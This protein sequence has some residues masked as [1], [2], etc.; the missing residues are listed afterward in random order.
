MVDSA[1][2]QLLTFGAIV[3]LVCGF[4]SSGGWFGKVPD[5]LLHRVSIGRWDGAMNGANRWRRTLQTLTNS[6]S[7]ADWEVMI[8]AMN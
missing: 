2:A 1:M 4:W 7:P 6:R 5:S 3:M 8:D